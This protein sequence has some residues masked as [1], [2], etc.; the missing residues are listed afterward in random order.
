MELMIQPTYALTPSEVVVVERDDDDL[1]YLWFADRRNDDVR[2]VTLTGSYQ[3][4][5]LH[6]ERDDQTWQAYGGITAVEF[7]GA[8]L[9]LH[10]DKA[11]AAALGGIE[12]VLVDC[13]SI[14]PSTQDRLE[15]LLAPLFAGTNVPVQIAH[16]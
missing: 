12:T 9:A 10:F 16:A 13:R 3:D 5:S 1:G 2:Y 11:A 7:D 14:Q 8:T 6:V 15:H 4:G